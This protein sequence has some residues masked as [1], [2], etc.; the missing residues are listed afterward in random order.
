MNHSAASTLCLVKLY[1]PSTIEKR[2]MKHSKQ[3]LTYI[4]IGA[5]WSLVQ[6]TSDLDRPIP[7]PPSAKTISPFKQM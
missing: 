5:V 4:V 1:R 3:P 7:I 6:N 2:D